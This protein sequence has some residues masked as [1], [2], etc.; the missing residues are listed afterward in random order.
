MQK[1]MKSSGIS[2]INHIRI[3]VWEDTIKLM[4][5]VIHMP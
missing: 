5:M 4:N 2:S 3:K 1:E